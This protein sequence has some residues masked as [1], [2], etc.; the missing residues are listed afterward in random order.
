MIAF[1]PRKI[2]R[3]TLFAQKVQV[4]TEQVPPGHPMI[5]LKSNKFNM[6]ATSP[7]RS[8]LVELIVSSLSFA[9][10]GW[11]ERN[12]K[13]EFWGQCEGHWKKIEHFSLLIVSHAI[14][15]LSWSYSFQLLISSRS[16]CKG[17]WY[18]MMKILGTFLN[19]VNNN[20]VSKPLRK[21][22]W[23]LPQRKSFTVYNFHAFLIMRSK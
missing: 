19:F 11:V 7:K 13:K 15:F 23:E 22:N 9:V 4:T 3:S 18:F 17:Q 14:I 6:A 1:S 8:V 12:K 21:W 2:Q 16:L 20:Y 10:R 5:L